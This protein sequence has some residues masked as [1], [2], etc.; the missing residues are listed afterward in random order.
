MRKQIP[1]IEVDGSGTRNFIPR[2]KTVG[3]KEKKSLALKSFW[4]QLCLLDGCKDLVRKV[5]VK[6]DSVV[7]HQLSRTSSFTLYYQTHSCR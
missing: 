1:E 5:A 4:L 7:M 3:S 2:R 6:G